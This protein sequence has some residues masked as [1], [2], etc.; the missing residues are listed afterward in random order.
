M[1]RRGGHP[2]D[3]VAGA[4]AGVR[5]DNGTV[6]A[7]RVALP[8]VGTRPMLARGA[9]EAIIGSDGSAEAIAAAATRAV[10]GVT[11]LE[12]LYG[13]EEYKA[14]LAEV[15]VARALEQAIAQA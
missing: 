7:A 3:A 5:K 8:G 10:E 9:T 11:V 1:G 12:D 14:H 4:A 2:D 6:H 13:S 15:F